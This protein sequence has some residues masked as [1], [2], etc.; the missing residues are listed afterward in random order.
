[1]KMNVRGFF[2]SK[3]GP[4]CPVYEVH[5]NC[6]MCLFAWVLKH[7]SNFPIQLYITLEDLLKATFPRR[8]HQWALKIQVP[9]ACM[10]KTLTVSGEST[11]SEVVVKLIEQL[12]RK[13]NVLQEHAK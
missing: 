10:S 5:I 6:V 4:I 1:M 13:L 11:V 2:P 8:M 9:D 12:G 7:L 3:S